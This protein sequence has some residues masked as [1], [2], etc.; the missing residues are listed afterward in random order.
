MFSRKSA[1][2][3]DDQFELRS[4]VASLAEIEWLLLLLVIL[5]YLAPGTEML[6]PEAM[7]VSMIAF[8]AFFICFNYFYARSDNHRWKLA[9]S[10]WVMIAFITW[11]IWNTGGV[12]SPLLNLYLL[13]II[14][15]AMTLGKLATLLEIVF[16]GAAFFFVAI[17]QSH[18]FSMAEFSRLMILFSPFVLVAWVT[19][20]LANDIHAGNTLFKSLANTDEMTGLLNKR[21]LKLELERAMQV[22]LQNKQTLT[23]MMFDADNLK[24]TNDTHGHAAGDRLIMHIATI[25]R[26]SFR[27]SDIVCRYGGD[28]FVAVLPQMGLAKALEISERIR[29]SVAQTTFSSDGTAL[30]TSVSVGFATWPDHMGHAKDITQLMVLADASLYESKRKGRNQVTHAGELNQARKNAI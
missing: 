20:L 5:Y 1:A 23:V 22:A 19:T 28:E 8:A 4:L 3:V 18:E 29:R 14:I 9:I 26:G 6:R 25:L 7:V 27:S 30:T 15:S 24:Q 13:V 11:V 12:Q 2:A 17:T 16:M 10:T 21:S